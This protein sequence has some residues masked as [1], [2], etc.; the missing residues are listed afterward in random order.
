LELWEIFSVFFKIGLVTLGGG[1]AMLAILQNDLVRRLKWL[2]GEKLID[3]YAISQSLPGLIGVNTAM[4]VGW[5][6]ARTPGLFAAALGVSAPSII[7]ILVVA[8]FIG[9]FLHVPAVK[10]AFNGV[11]AAVAAIIVDAVFAMW[12]S[13]VKDKPTFVIFLVSLA[14]LAL[15]PT[16]SP[17]IPVVAGAIAGVAVKTAAERRAAAQTGGG[18]R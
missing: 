13:G 11:R 5:H 7:V 17:V 16:M 9:N 8:M 18:P 15:A 4:F 1:Y 3:F 6:K 2:P 12:K 10:F 14:A